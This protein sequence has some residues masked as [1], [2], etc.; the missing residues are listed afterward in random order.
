MSSERGPAAARTTDKPVELGEPYC[1]ECGHRLTGCVDSSRCPECGRPLVEVLVRG[2]KIGNRYRSQ[3]L[4]FGLPLVDVAY[5]PTHNEKLGRAR[6]IFAFGDRATGVVAVGG[7]ATGIVAV[8]GRAI[9]CF[10]A[11]GVSFGLVTAWG[12]I[13]VGGMANGGLAVGVLVMAG[14]SL[15]WFAGG[16]VPI[17]WY[18]FG[19]APIGTHANDAEVLAML[20]NLTFYFG[21]PQLTIWTFVMPM[22]VVF[23]SILAWGALTGLVA[24]VTHAL[25]GRR[26]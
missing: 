18:A 4:L 22:I 1:A 2:G 12:G 5:G 9:G 14:L 17:G 24:V 8:G 7:A 15:G 21:T 23:G 11:G 19:G 25:R 10:S 13:A 3:T 16:G 6:G 26:G 20:E